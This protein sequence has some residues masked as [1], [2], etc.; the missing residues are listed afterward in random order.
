MVYYL[1]E[2]TLAEG[3]QEDMRMKHMHIP[4]IMLVVVLALTVMVLPPKS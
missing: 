3:M 4:I 2:S 1:N